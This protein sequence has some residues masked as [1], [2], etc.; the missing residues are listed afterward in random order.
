MYKKNSKPFSQS[1]Q[2]IWGFTN[3][4]L[5]FLT[6]LHPQVSPCTASHPGWESFEISAWI[7]Y[8]LN[9]GYEFDEIQ[10]DGII[11]CK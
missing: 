8:Q 2:Y 1:L 4:F 5:S 3:F 6:V 9:T 7:S 10:I 11:R